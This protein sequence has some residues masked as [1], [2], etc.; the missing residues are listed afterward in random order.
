MRIA[1][2]QHKRAQEILTAPGPREVV[3]VWQDERTGLWCRIR[4]DQLIHD[5][6]EV[7]DKLHWSNSNLKST[8]KSASP[9]R[10]PRD[11]ERMGHYFKAAL[12]RMG[13]EELGF[14]VQN[15]LYPVVEQVAPHEVIVYRLN[16]DALDI[17][18]AE[19]RQ[20]LDDLAR[21]VESG[22]WPGYD[23]KVHDLNLPE[24]RREQA[25]NLAFMGV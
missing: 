17:G 20:A 7:D 24:Y 4:P 18:E 6:A 23:R 12:Y 5:P 2:S 21:C 14:P 8:S 13:L 1:L 16:E 19:V 15:F 3:G 25:G 9:F 10:F 11:F 22:H